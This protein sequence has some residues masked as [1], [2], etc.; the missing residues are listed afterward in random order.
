VKRYRVTIDGR[1][2]DVE[3]DDP[4]A[5]PVTARLSGVAYSV[6]VEPDRVVDDT[7][8]RREPGADGPEWGVELAPPTAS[9]APAGD[10]L[11]AGP[12]AMTAPIPGVVAAV[13]VEAGD[14][15]ERGDELLTLDAM[16]MMNVIRSPW[17]GTV[18]T[19]HVEKGDRVVQ[20]EP[21]VTF[22]PT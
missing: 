19:I 17:E 7:S 20:G 6:D 5:R 8:P 2:Y 12:R 21:L 10:P 9:T 15:I 11:K 4:N 13:M 18:A 1:I 14:T 16:K 3:I 22:V